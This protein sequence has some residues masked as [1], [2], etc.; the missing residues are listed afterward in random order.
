MF[1][2]VIVP[3]Q[4]ASP[5]AQELGRRIAALIRDYRLQHQDASATDVHFALRIA[6]EEAGGVERRRRMILL[7]GVLAA[8][9]GAGL[10]FFARAGRGEAAFPLVFVAALILVVLLVVVALK[11]R[12]G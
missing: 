12:I 10:V 5:H 4:D 9:L 3:T 2:P 7:G 8:I 6:A 1:V 11:S